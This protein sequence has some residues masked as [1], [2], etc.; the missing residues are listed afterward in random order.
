[1]KIEFWPIG[2]VKPYELNS[3]IHDKEQVGK[4]AQSI[5]KFGFDQ[6]IVVDKDGVI[7]K[8]HGRR[9]AC[10]EL[11]LK[12]VPVLI[13]EDLTTEQA[14][15]ARVADNRVAIGD[16]DINLLKEEMAA[17]DI[18]DLIGIFD[19]KELAFTTEDITSLVDTSAFASDLDEVVREQASELD[20]R[21]DAAMQK[22]IPVSK[23]LGIKDFSA[24]D[25]IYVTRFMGQVEAQTNCKG[26]VALVSYIKSI[27]QE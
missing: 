5:K 24:G 17:I 15:A 20:T 12:E 14:N 3:K 6:P 25:M 9:L 22:R 19:D 1:M 11:G 16:I 10:I 26:D 27:L 4:I 8:G 2:L 18:E 13:R 23:A 7:I 21:I